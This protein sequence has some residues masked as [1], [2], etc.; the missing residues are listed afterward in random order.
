[1]IVSTTAPMAMKAV[2]GCSTMNASAYVGDSAARISGCRTMCGTPRTARTTNHTA[3]TGPKAF[4]TASVPHRWTTNSTVRTTTE[5][6][7]TSCLSEG[8]TTTRPSIADMTEIAGVMTLS[9]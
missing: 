4:P 9:P 2:N 1:V 6:G 7:S 5:T 3:M 8:L